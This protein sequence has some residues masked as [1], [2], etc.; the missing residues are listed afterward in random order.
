MR[1]SSSSNF[2]E[3][4]WSPV[5]NE[6]TLDCFLATLTFDNRSFIYLRGPDGEYVKVS[7]EL[8][9]LLKAHYARTEWP[10]LAPVEEILASLYDSNRVTPFRKRKDRKRE[11]GVLYKLAKAYSTAL[12]SVCWK[13]SLVVDGSAKTHAVL[14]TATRSGYVVV[15]RVFPDVTQP[16]VHTSLKQISILF[17][18]L[19]LPCRMCTSTNCST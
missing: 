11:D 7:P 10:D 5:V 9:E 17:L 4:K 19:F 2:A 1:F 16:Q 18:F 12:T 15:W 14:L 3:A 6:E 13:K 8:S